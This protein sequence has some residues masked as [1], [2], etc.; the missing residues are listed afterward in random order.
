MEIG[1]ERLPLADQRPFG[2]QRLLDFDDQIRPAEDFFGAAD[3]FAA[4]PQVVVI[5][6]ART[7]PRA[8]L[9]EYLVP[10]ADELLDAHRQ[11]RHTIFVLLDLLRYTHD[12]GI[13]LKQRFARFNVRSLERDAV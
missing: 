5:G 11:H 3:Q 2:R 13:G 9:D 10:A 7:E 4:L 6:D 8:G 1:E 12:H